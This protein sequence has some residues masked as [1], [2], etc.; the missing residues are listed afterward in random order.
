MRDC[1]DCQDLQTSRSVWTARD[2][3]PLF[4]PTSF[5]LDGV[6]VFNSYDKYGYVNS[7]LNPGVVFIGQDLEF[8]SMTKYFYT[9][10]SVPKKKLTE[11]EMLEINRLYRIIG[12][13]EKELAQLQHP[14]TGSAETATEPTHDP[15]P[16]ANYIYAGIGILLVLALYAVSKR[17]SQ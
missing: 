7:D 2:L 8:N 9:D 6:T 17:R 14:D 12:R 3:S 11:P 5:T 1:R 13:C 4:G 16:R 10:R 15:I